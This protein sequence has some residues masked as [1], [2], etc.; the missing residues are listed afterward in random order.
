M[1]KNDYVAGWIIQGKW[2]QPLMIVTLSNHVRPTYKYA[3][4][5]P[6]LLEFVKDF[7]L[8]EVGVRIVVSIQEAG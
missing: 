2:R 3:L 8:F 7:H 1:E 5:H 4:R 6:L